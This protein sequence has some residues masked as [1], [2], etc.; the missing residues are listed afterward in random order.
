M[1]RLKKNRSVGPTS[2]PLS[3]FRG[4]LLSLLAGLIVGAAAGT[5]I[6]GFRPQALP[7]LVIALS[8]LLGAS[9]IVSGLRGRFITMAATLAGVAAIASTL[10]M[11]PFGFAVGQFDVVGIVG[12]TASL[13]TLVLVQRQ[14]RIALHQVA[15]ARREIKLVSDDLAYSREQSTLTRAQLTELARLPEL[16]LTFMNGDLEK[17]LLPVRAQSVFSADLLIHN[18]G[19]RTAR[20]A[21][22]EVLIPW[23]ALEHDLSDVNMSRHPDTEVVAGVPYRRF[24]KQ[25]D[26]PIY[27]DLERRISVFAEQLV[28]NP[29]SF[30]LL[31]RLRDDYAAYPRDG[32][33]GT[34][35]VRCD[36]QRFNR[37]LQFIKRWNAEP[38]PMLAWDRSSGDAFVYA[39]LIPDPSPD[40]AVF[41]ETLQ[42]RVEQLVLSMPGLQ[43]TSPRIGEIGV[44]FIQGKPLEPL[45]C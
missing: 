3:H 38:Y 12:A 24:G 13:V 21:Y 1:Q 7:P 29:P 2:V 36:A 31:W 35:E 8:L 41:D 6:A 18:I 32:S 37:R 23:H 9:L 28:S 45:S 4:P 42:Q 40:V 20:D 26:E 33:L 25:I 11:K 15:L 14:I 19:A 5:A 34:L 22:V 39:S 43:S 27:R 44:E 30:S 16:S 10:L 17:A